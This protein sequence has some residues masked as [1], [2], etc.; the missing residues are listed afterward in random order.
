M[1]LVAPVSCTLVNYTVY[2][3]L[4][5]IHMIKL[6]LVNL[7]LPEDHL[8]DHLRLTGKNIVNRYGTL[9]SSYPQSERGR[10]QWH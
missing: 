6:T 2:M 1:K 9:W 4:Y 5:T 7:A 10:F 3:I 8:R